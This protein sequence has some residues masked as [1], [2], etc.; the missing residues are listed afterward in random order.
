M[1]WTSWLLFIYI[2]LKNSLGLDEV[3]S[4]KRKGKIDFCCIAL[5][6]SHIEK[7]KMHTIME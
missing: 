7:I 4:V 1:K 5:C 6:I 3:G 2:R